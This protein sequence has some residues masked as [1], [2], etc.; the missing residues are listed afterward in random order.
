[1]ESELI[2]LQIELRT[3]MKMLEH[4]A[5][6]QDTEA[7]KERRKAK[8]ALQKNERNFA[9]LYCTNAVRAEQQAL[10]LRQNAAKLSSIICDLKMAQT[11]KQM[12]KAMGTT[13]KELQKAVGSMD[14]SKIA[15]ATLQYD[16]IRGKM[17]TVNTLT[18][19]TDATIENGSTDLL[20]QLEN[21][22]MTEQLIDLDVPTSGLTEP[23]T[24]EQG[25]QKVAGAGV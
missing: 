22:M 10:F 14:L 19:P 12:L 21:E 25:R 17:D 9:N 3:Q 5:K 8:L 11:Q 15:N 20:A 7:A 16:K 24:E 1:M 6:K 18:A 2:N 23:T 4:Q 13:T